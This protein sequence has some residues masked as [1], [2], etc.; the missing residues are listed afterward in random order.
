MANKRY[1]S[2]IQP[3]GD[4]HLGNYLGAIR[5]WVDES[6]KEGEHFYFIA[7]LHAMT[8]DY[9][10]AE[11]QDRIFKTVTTLMAC[12]L[13]PANVTLFRQS[14]VSAHSELAWILNT[15]ASMGQL[16]RMTQFKEKTYK[17]E[18]INVGIFA[19][20]VLMSAD[21]LLYQPDF[22]PVGEDQKQH[23]ELCRDLAE[24]FNSRFGD[25]FRVP[26]PAIR[27]EGAR[28]MGLMDPEKKMSKSDQVADQCIFILDTPEEITRKIK[29]ATTDSERTIVFDEKR[30]GLFNLLTI[31]QM[32]S[33]KEKKA[34]ESEFEGKGYKEF[35]ES[36]AE[37]IIEALR[38]IQERYAKLT[39]DHSAVEKALQDGLKKAQPIAA[40][41]LLKAQKNAGLR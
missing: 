36:L 4:A 26:A 34:I 38:P 7:D 2:G 3:S 19:Y 33:G 21:I 41:T 14:Q 32:L 11:L 31:Y 22:V 17:S 39:K 10:P 37:V 9:K 23:V 27:K 28:I 15:I 8:V 35:K 29:K 6:K 12:G 30:K 16:E 25:T 13:D 40:D 18:S 1:L 5:N 20:P 24:R